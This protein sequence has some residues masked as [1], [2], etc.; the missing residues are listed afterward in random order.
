MSWFSNLIKGKGFGPSYQDPAAAGRAGLDK[1]PGTMKPY[2]DPYIDRGREA[3]DT[4]HQQYGDMTNNPGE[5]Y[6]NLGKGYT[7]SPGYKNKMEAAMTAGTNAAASG[8]ML[9]TPQDEEARGNMAGDVANQD[10]Q[11]YMDHMMQVFGQG[12]KGQ[13]SE[14]A[15]G[16]GASTQLGEDLGGVEGRK[17]QLDYEG[18][19]GKNKFNAQ[20]KK[21]MMEALGGLFSHTD[22]DGKGGD[23]GINMETLMKFLP[24]LLA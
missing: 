16:Y 1:I 5:F 21:D 10:Y 23:L 19:A 14:E 7:Q 11:A 20:R 15:Q 12:Q 8:G 24:F 4:L 17:A 2:F 6:S 18:V 3:G 9:G 22:K 13:Q